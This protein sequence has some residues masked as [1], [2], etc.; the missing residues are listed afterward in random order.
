MIY[1]IAPTFK[2]LDHV[3]KFIQCWRDTNRLD[4]TIV[5]CNGSPGDETSDFISSTKSNCSVIEL[6]GNPSLF[7]SGLVSL[8][9][10]YVLRVADIHDNVIF[11]NVD[12]TFD[13]ENLGKLC[14]LIDERR[15]QIG[16][17]VKSE[18]G[19]YLSSGVR[20]ISWLLSINK[21]PF[22]GLKSLPYVNE[23]LVEVTFLP[24]RFLMMPIEA[25]HI[26]GT[27][28]T[29]LLPHY[30][31][32][33]EFTNRVR[34]AGFTPYIS[35]DCYVEVDES[36]TGSN[37]ENRPASVFARLQSLSDIKSP[38]NIKYRSSFIYL[39][40]PL[41]CVPFSLL[42]NY[43]KIGYWVLVDKK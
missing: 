40:S 2:E 24:T 29:A 17:L 43:L 42:V 14:R 30:G 12:V 35:R 25:L 39:V 7:W 16:A 1:V 9:V 6:S 32:D 34:L 37:V 22:R 41:F 18:K 11:A 33:Y 38:F 4:Y 23:E 20:V 15:V 31:G 19:C 28:N 10:E 13:S 5:I 3:V 21:H 8:G 36:N 26:V 27:P